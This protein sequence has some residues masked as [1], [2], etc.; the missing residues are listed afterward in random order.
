M[1]RPETPAIVET[2][3][4]FTL[5]IV[6]FVLA[7]LGAV[8]IWGVVRDLRGGE[9]WNRLAA[10]AAIG[11]TLIFGG[12]QSLYVALTGRVRGRINRWLSATWQSLTNTTPP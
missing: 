11:L 12:A 4:R 5:T 10:V 6:G 1:P 3:A 8:L 9:D 7:G 2:S